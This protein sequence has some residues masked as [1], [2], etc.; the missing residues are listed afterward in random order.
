MSYHSLSR[1][2]L[3]SVNSHAQCSSIQVFW[4]KLSDQNHAYMS[5][6]GVVQK[7]EFSRACPFLYCVG[8]VA[9]DLSHSCT[10]PFKFMFLITVLKFEISYVSPSSTSF[11]HH[12]V[13]SVTGLELLTSPLGYSMWKTGLLFCVK[14]WKLLHSGTAAHCSFTE[15]W[16]EGRTSWMISAAFLSP[17]A[18]LFCCAC[19]ARNCTNPI[20][21]CVV[22]S[23][24]TLC[25]SFSP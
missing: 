22:M 25:P 14:A 11:L 17:M 21:S 4:R 19:A 18:R 12:F 1:I 23:N 16:T 15:N 24:L 8:V 20:E 3:A 7:M 13:V 9:C 6:G 5:N 2:D 10:Q